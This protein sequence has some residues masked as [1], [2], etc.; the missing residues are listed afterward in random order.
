[1]GAV[2]VLGDVETLVVW[3]PRTMMSR[4]P[5]LMITTRR[6]RFRTDTPTPLL[7]TDTPR[8][9]PARRLRRGYQPQTSKP[10]NTPEPGK[11]TKTPTS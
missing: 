9:W 7:P 6:R 11:P 2:V 4:A 8:R 1:M 5:A 10:T 3:S